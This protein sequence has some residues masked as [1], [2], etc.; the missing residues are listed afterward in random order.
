MSLAMTLFFSAEKV[1]S[2][3]AIKGN[4]RYVLSGAVGLDSQAYAARRG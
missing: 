1:Q 4:L 3:R 2:D